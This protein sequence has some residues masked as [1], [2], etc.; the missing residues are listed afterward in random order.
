MTAERE[1]VVAAR[2]AER[3]DAEEA[4]REARAEM[5]ALR[6]WRAVCREGAAAAAAAAAGEDDKDD[7]GDA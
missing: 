5:E 7:D 4:F 2:D 6:S 1:S 3:R